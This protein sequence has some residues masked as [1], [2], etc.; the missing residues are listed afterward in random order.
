MSAPD[1]EWRWP[2]EGRLDVVASLR[3]LRMGPHDRTKRVM[4]DQVWLATR[5]HSGPVTLCL[6][7][8]GREAVVRGWGAGV[9]AIAPAL[10]ALL[11]LHDDPTALVPRH[12]TVEQLARDHPG[13]R[14][15]RAPNLFEVLVTMVL[16]QRVKFED[17]AAGY[18]ALTRRYGDPAPGPER[19]R[20]PPDPARLA[21]LPYYAYHPCG[22]ERRRAETLRRISMHRAKV[23]QWASEAQDSAG[24]RRLYARLLA[25]SGLG[26]WTVGMTAGFGI[27]DPDALV[28]G[29]F[30]LPNVVAWALSRKPRGDDAMMMRCLE[31]Y[32]G[33]RWRVVRLLFAG[34][35][36]APRYGAKRASP[37]WMLAR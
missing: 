4:R 24:Y 30:H 3:F 10:P 16:Q 19:L 22:I 12:R 14:L 35:V 29:D 7:A 9:E 13:L 34:G 33:Q 23:A 32:R 11:G 5:T 6:R 36:H 25:M 15:T 21:A 37:P 2:L 26:P 1:A 8:P 17:A 28:C 31:P 20:L 27:G 18:L